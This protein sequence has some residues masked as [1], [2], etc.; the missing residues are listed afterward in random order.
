MGC[1]PHARFQESKRFPGAVLGAGEKANLMVQPL[2]VSP[3][4]G[5]QTLAGGLLKFSH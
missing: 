5:I 1:S 4:F 3:R 2:S